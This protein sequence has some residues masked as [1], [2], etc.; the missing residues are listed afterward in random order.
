VIR[1]LR[2]NA[3]SNNFQELVI[4]QMSSTH[5]TYRGHQNSSNGN[6]QH[7]VLQQDSS[8]NNAPNAVDHRN[9]STGNVQEVLEEQNMST[10]KLLHLAQAA[11]GS[12]IQIPADALTSLLH[13][14]NSLQTSV[15][16]LKRENRGLQQT[17]GSVEMNVQK[18]LTYSGVTFALFPRLPLQIQQMIWRHSANI[19]QIIGIEVVMMNG[20]WHFMPAAA[21]NQQLLVCKEARSEASKTRWPLVRRS[22]FK[23]GADSNAPKISLNQITDTLWLSTDD[24]YYDLNALSRLYCLEAADISISPKSTRLQSHTRNGVTQLV[25]LSFPTCRNFIILKTKQLFLVV[26]DHSA[27]NASGIVFIKP[28]APPSSLISPEIFANSRWAN[29]TTWAMIEEE[30]MKGTKY[31][32]IKRAAERKEYFLSTSLISF[33]NKVFQTNETQKQGYRTRTMLTTTLST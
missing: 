22:P 30:D 32:Q 5:S 19:P 13:S 12:I 8:T 21:N 14:L 2:T 33:L 6:V 24:A 18:L 7:K 17:L 15:I 25:D 26:G 20:S 29:N 16:E 23:S 3:A 27:R 11:S 9:S 10:H 1:V 4:Q 31:M 28:R